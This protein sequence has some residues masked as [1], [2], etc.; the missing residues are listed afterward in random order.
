LNKNEQQRKKGTR[1][2]VCSYYKNQEY[3][4]RQ[5]QNDNTRMQLKMPQVLEMM[6]KLGR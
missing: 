1:K 2:I 4:Q 6:K 5:Q 3:L